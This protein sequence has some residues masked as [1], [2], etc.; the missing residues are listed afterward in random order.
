[1]IGVEAGRAGEVAQGSSAFAIRVCKHGPDQTGGVVEAVKAAQ[2]AT[3][4]R[5]NL[6]LR[7]VWELRSPELADVVPA[8]DHLVK[9]ERSGLLELNED[10]LFGRLVR[11]L[12][13][14][15]G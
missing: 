11:Q 6:K 15:V 12:I 8:L 3:I 13:S 1:M 7:D 10:T 4:L 2:I 14:I 9:A 5:L